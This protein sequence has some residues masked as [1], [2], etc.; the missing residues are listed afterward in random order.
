MKHHDD[1]LA[2]KIFSELGGGHGFLT[3]EAISTNGHS[4]QAVATILQWC[5]AGF[6]SYFLSI[7]RLY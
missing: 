2:H 3:F 7:Y 5:S 4:S 6:W 1:K